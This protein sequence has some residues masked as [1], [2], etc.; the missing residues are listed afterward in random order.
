MPTYKFYPVD[1]SGRVIHPPHIVDASND[2]EAL[3]KARSQLD[4]HD[5]DGW[6]GTRRIGLLKHDE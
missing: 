5:L 6:E 4:G 1:Q 2:L 3:E